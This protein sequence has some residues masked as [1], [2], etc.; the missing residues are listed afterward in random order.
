MDAIVARDAAP[1][2]TTRD[3]ANDASNDSSNDAANDDGSVRDVWYR[4]SFDDGIGFFS[5]TD[6]QT[7]AG[8]RDGRVSDFGGVFDEWHTPNLGDGDRSLTLYKTSNTATV[9]WRLT[10]VNDTSR[11]VEGV[12][13]RYDVE[14]A[15]VRFQS[16]DELAPE[17]ETNA[18]RVAWYL[19]GTLL[20]RSGDVVNVSVS[21]ADRARWLT[22]EDQ[23]R[24]GLRIVGVVHELPEIRVLPGE[25]WVVEWGFD[26]STTRAERHMSVGIDD[27]VVEAMNE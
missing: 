7:P 19:G 24:L 26:P 22:H 23:D 21:E 12:R 4:E 1:D 17:Y 10:L 3:A 20:A 6:Q 5:P 8:Y 25:T 16:T 2:G 15:W 13:L 18:H 9:R 11:T 27:L 14:T